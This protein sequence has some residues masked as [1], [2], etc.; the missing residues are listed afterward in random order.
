MVASFHRAVAENAD[1][2]LQVRDAA[3]LARVESGE[4]LGLMLAL[5]GVECFGVE[6]WPAEVFHAL[7][8]RMAGLTWNRR[9]AFADG[10]A[11]DGGGLSR[12]G[13]ELVD[14]LVELG[15]VLDL[16]HASRGVF[17]ELLERAAGA[18]ILCSHGGCRAVNDTPRNLDDDQLRALAR[19]RRPLR[20]DAPPDRDRTRR[21]TIDRRDRP[22]RARGLGDGR[23]P[24]V[25]RGRLH[26]AASGRRC[27]LRPSR[28][29][30][31]CRRAHAGH[32][33][34]GLDGSEHYPDLLARARPAR[35]AQ[36][37]VAAVTPGT[38]SA[39]C[40][41]PS[42]RGTA[43]GSGRPRRRSDGSWSSGCSVRSR[44]SPTT[45][46]RSRSGAASRVRSSRRSS[47]NR[48]ASSRP[49][50]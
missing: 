4:R 17:A 37:E 13:R 5:E 27:R 14:R 41:G 44:S 34:R 9:N 23:R 33:D 8:V 2:V 12:L 28:R 31:S 32:R 21:R 6:I 40:A 36:D 16:A 20:A 1:R 48:T 43:V 15:V 10:A 45:E 11:E 30:G 38:C 25:P 46:R 47:W 42:R 39:S 22:P 18:P 24:R 19:R 50:A 26:E 3:D 7:G 49:T 29:T 35:L